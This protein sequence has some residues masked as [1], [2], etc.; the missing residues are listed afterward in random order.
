MPQWDEIQARARKL[1]DEGLKLLRAGMSDA[2][3]LAEATATAA[4]LHVAL[5]RNRL[6]KYRLLHEIGKEVCAAVEADPA[7]RQ[8]SI[9]E[10]ISDEIARSRALDE[11]MK[12]AEAHI[13]GLS[14]VRK[15]ASPT[16]GDEDDE[17][18]DDG[19][20]DGPPQ[21]TGACD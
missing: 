11:E 5:R 6:D 14:V 17:G 8:I 18:D 13:S 2:E 3:Y 12:R 9:T 21:D 19:D 10:S 20:D 15:P 16:E 1:I 7:L 4:K